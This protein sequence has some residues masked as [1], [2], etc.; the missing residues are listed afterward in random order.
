MAEE[1]LG[2]GQDD[3]L[4][5]ICCVT[6]GEFFSLT[7]SQCLFLSRDDPLSP[8]GA[9]TR[10]RALSSP[11]PTPLSD[12]LVLAGGHSSQ[13]LPQAR[14]REQQQ[15]ARV[16]PTPISTLQEMPPSPRSCVSRKQFPTRVS[17]QAERGG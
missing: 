13:G 2:R 12:S 17:K 15:D 6:Q 1:T 10:A 4:L 16:T 8:E 7:G 14:P 9:W 5:R 11:A 3:E